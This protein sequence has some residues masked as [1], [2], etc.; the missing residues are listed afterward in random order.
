MLTHAE[1]NDAAIVTSGFETAAV[2]NIGVIRNAEIRRAAN[3]HWQVW[4]E[5]VDDL[6]AGDARGDGF[7]IIETRQMLLPIIRQLAFHRDVPQR[8]E[9][10]MLI[11]VRLH[12]LFPFAL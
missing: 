9:I 3:Q 4:R 5:G 11:L 8:T 12:Q 1:V 2:F 6:S 10:R 7:G